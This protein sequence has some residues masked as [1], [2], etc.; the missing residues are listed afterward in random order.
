[1]CYFCRGVFYAAACLDARPARCYSGCQ[2][3]WMLPKPASTCR[4][5]AC[6]NSTLRCSAGGHSH[7]LRRAHC[8]TT[9]CSGLTAAP[10]CCGSAL[11]DGSLEAARR[12]S[13][14]EHSRPSRWLAGVPT[15]SCLIV[16]AL[17]V[18]A[19]AAAAAAPGLGEEGWHA[20]GCEARGVTLAR[21]GDHRPCRTR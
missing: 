11:G 15:L 13:P 18:G 6:K 17:S 12:A 10:Y 2:I 16:C 20:K 7:R 14:S 19:S 9:G 1:M 5:S 4:G 3:T 8:C 21:Q